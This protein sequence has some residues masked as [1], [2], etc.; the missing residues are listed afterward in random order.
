MISSN[1]SSNLVVTN[2]NYTLYELKIVMINI[3]I[4]N[5]A[6]SML[7]ITKLASMQI[8]EEELTSIIA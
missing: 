3:V 1:L 6:V 7:F 2:L 8:F 5:A 4:S